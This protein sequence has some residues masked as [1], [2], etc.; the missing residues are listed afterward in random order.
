M[1]EN[2][3]KILALKFWQVRESKD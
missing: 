3:G 2:M 1:V